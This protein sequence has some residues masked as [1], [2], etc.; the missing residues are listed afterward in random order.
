MEKNNV[1]I[2]V[3]DQIPDDYEPVLFVTNQRRVCAGF[4]DAVEKRFILNGPHHQFEYPA[5]EIEYWMP[6]PKAPEVM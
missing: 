3:K 6:Y 2:N 5:D 4:Y 1:W